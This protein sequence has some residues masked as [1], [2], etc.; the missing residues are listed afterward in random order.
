MHW[1]Y[2]GTVREGL[3]GYL[4]IINHISS[5][6]RSEE[7][8]NASFQWTR[9]ILIYWIIHI[10]NT[11]AWLW[12][13]NEWGRIQKKRKHLSGRLQEFKKKKFKPFI[14]PVNP[15]SSFT[16]WDSFGNQ[17][18]SVIFVKCKQILETLVT[19]GEI[20]SVLSACYHLLSKNKSVCLALL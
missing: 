12:Q 10:S 13:Y 18:E 5:F 20:I 4:L 15:A 1:F 2:W 7:H 6:S 16:V 11:A 3:V 14:I 9:Q 8:S 17:S 19:T